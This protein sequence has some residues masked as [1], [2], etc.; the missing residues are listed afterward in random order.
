MLSPSLDVG[1]GL[2]WQH[3][4]NGRSGVVVIQRATGGNELD[5]L[6]GLVVVA[7]T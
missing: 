7:D 2:P 4:R 1:L 6:G 5:Q 3:D